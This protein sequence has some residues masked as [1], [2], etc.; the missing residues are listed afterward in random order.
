[1]VYCTVF[2]FSYDILQRTSQRPR[3]QP[4][5]KESCKAPEPRSP[6]CPPSGWA[7]AFHSFLPPPGCQWLSSLAG[8]GSR[9]SKWAG[10]P[11]HPLF[12][13]GH[14][15]PASG[16]LLSGEET[17]RAKRPLLCSQVTDRHGLEEM[18]GEQGLA[19]KPQAAP[20][21]P[22]W[23]NRTDP[24][25]RHRKSSSLRG[26]KCLCEEGRECGARGPEG[27]KEE[28]R[29]GGMPPGQHLWHQGALGGKRRG[30]KGQLAGD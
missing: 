22:T 27:G 24:S 14:R 4:H 20:G 26:Q 11:G 10:I 25:I 18:P 5:G 16:S 6:G 28:G 8:K 7:P 19:P 30:R 13:S 1:M 9:G 12:G 29:K 17:H 2:F 21:P 3:G 23:P 15:G